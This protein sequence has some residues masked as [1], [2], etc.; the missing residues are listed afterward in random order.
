MKGSNSMT[1][2]FN[3]ELTINMPDGG[4]HAR[5]LLNLYH[6]N[7]AVDI[8]EAAFNLCNADESVQARKFASLELKRSEVWSSQESSLTIFAL[9]SVHGEDSHFIKQVITS[10]MEGIAGCI[11]EA[12]SEYFERLGFRPDVSFQPTDWVVE[13]HQL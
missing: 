4:R 1:S 6:T 5:Q 2:L 13:V 8:N 11:D 7:M 9:L 10:Y 3:I 12:S